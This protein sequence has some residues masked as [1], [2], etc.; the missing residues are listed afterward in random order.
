MSEY[1]VWSKIDKS[2]LITV[3]GILL[4]FASAVGVTLVAPGLID[5]SWT[6]PS[7]EYQVQMHEV[8]D[9]NTYISVA[10]RGQTSLEVVHHLK[11][12]FSL[13][14]FAETKSTR[15]L[16]SHELEKYVTR[17]GDEELKLTSDLLLLRAPEDKTAE[18]ALQKALQKEWAD[19]HA[20]EGVL[21]FQILE[22]Y[23]PSKSEAF[24]LAHSDGVTEDWVDQRYKVIDSPL[25]QDFHKN[26]G[27]IYIRNPIEYRVSATRFAN[28]ETW[29]YD[30]RGRAV[31]SLEELKKENLGF[32]SREDL[33]YDGEHI[34]AI[35]GCWY[36]HT[37]QTRTLIQ[38]TVLN[39]S[40]SFPAPPSSANEYIY[41][42]I[43]FLGTRRI[44]PD[45]S[46]VGIKRPSRDW[47][48]SHFWSPKTAS[49]GSIMPAFRFFFDDD[50]RGTSKSEIGVPN[51]KF[52]AVYQ[53]LMTKGT[54]ITAPTQAWWLG[55]DPVQTIDIIEGKKE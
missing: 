28:E 10:V 5:P 8:A 13:L 21:H 42:R 55:K 27:V 40:E 39:G 43:T 46:R 26:T 11:K 7:S 31:E 37:V 52:E 32:R 12:D 34:V 14:A 48:K 29:Q 18:K 53:W 54:R 51:Y 38:D 49:P 47:N 16:A 22:L 50:P 45:L 24:S 36:C 3:I 35:N 1:G 33:I 9:P 30:P 2:A 44:G 4:L 6:E 20:G 23:D 17:Y 19:E 25:R 15:I 41:E